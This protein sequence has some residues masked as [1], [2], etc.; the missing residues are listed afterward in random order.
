[1]PF[2]HNSRSY[3]LEV[4]PIKRRRII[5]EEKTSETTSRAQKKKRQSKERL[6]K[7][8]RP[9]NPTHISPKKKNSQRLRQPRE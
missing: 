2:Y 1:M 9:L 7:N 8:K 4:V 6:I 3:V 5:K